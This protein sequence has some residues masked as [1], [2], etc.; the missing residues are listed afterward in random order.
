MEQRTTLRVLW[1]GLVLMT[2]ACAIV[3]MRQPMRRQALPFESAGYRLPLNRASAAQLQALP[4]IGPTLA[5][6]V[7][8]HRQQIGGFTRVQQ[9]EDVHLL[10]PITRQRIEPWVRL[11]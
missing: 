1:L 3:M 10:G 8:A 6:R 11:D 5:Q 4:G 2:L 9:L 7:V